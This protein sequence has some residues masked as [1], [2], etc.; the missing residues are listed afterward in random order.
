MYM[1]E[2]WTHVVLVRRAYGGRNGI[3]GS[4]CAF[5]GSS[6]MMFLSVFECLWGSV[7]VRPPSFEVYRRLSSIYKPSSMTIWRRSSLVV[8][9]KEVST[10]QSA[11]TFTFTD[12]SAQWSSGKEML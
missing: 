10:H 12:T 9:R 7:C 6:E 4:D 11:R 8:C 1:Y 2:V 3:R 5:D